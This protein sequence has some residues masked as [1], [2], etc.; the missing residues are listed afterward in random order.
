MHDPFVFVNDLPLFILFYGSLT[1]TQGFYSDEYLDTIRHCTTARRYLLLRCH[2]AIM[3]DIQLLHLSRNILL[4]NGC[5][6]SC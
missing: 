4:A 2:V 3:M 6:L 1:L 5:L